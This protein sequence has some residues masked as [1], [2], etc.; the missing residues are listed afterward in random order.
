MKVLRQICAIT[1]LTVVLSHA[2]LAD[3]GVIHPG[4]APPPP[5]PPPTSG[6]IHPGSTAP[7]EESNSEDGPVD[8]ITEITL[9]LVQNLLALF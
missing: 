2:A 1:V 4:Y 8:L 5:P 6:V 9:N 7:N 3:E